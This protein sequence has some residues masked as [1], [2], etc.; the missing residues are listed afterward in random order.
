MS[1]LWEKV[2]KLP[3]RIL[4]ISCHLN[5]FLM[6]R[7]PNAKENTI[8]KRQLQWQSKSRSPRQVLSIR[9]PYRLNTLNTFE[10][11]KATDLP[12]VTFA[13]KHARGWLTSPQLTYV[14][15]HLMNT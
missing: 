12:S 10:I 9:L 1:F 2:T 4:V 3:F 7:E 14:S 8:Q 11:S 6:N 5:P 13:R 15:N